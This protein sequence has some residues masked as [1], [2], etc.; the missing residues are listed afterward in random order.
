MLIV[1][2]TPPPLLLLLHGEQQHIHLAGGKKKVERQQFFR[3]NQLTATDRVEESSGGDSKAVYHA[4]HWG[5]KQ[6]NVGPMFAQ[7][8]LHM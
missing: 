1:E 4:Q 5:R 6:C 2:A 7:V 3:L 8:L